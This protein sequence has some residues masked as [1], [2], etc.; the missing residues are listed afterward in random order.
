MVQQDDAD[1]GLKPSRSSI[2]NPNFSL[3]SIIASASRLA[4]PAVS[5]GGTSLRALR[6]SQAPSP[7]QRSTR[8]VL[9]SSVMKA[10]QFFI[11][12]L[13]APADAGS[14]ESPAHDAGGL[15]QGLGAGIYSYMP[16]GLRDPQGRGDHPRGDEPRR[17][18][19]V[20]DAGRSRPSC[21]RRAALQATAGA[22]A[23][24]GP[25][26]ARFHRSSRRARKSSPTSRARNCAATGSCRRT[27]ITSRPSSATRRPR[28]GLMRG[29]EFTMKDAY[30]FDRDK[31]GA[32]KSYEI[33]SR[34]YRAIFDRF[35]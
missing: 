20:A 11:S 23:H 28:F 31:A 21:G 15:R 4:T 30:S 3:E 27:S 32:A 14:Q 22:A 12:T 7:L 24:Q 8:I 9:P 2:I 5:R 33:M 26:P 16:M 10:S 29:R 34:A 25:S 6:G 17:R 18:G 13:K 19:R 1:V 35:G